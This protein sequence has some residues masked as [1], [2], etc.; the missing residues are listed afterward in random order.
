VLETRQTRVEGRQPV[1]IEREGAR[2]LDVRERGPSR[3]EVGLVEGP[4][5]LGSGSMRSIE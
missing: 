3:R 4:H 1:T 5:A 2:R